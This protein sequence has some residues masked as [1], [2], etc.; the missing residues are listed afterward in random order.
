MFIQKDGSY[1]LIDAEEN[2]SLLKK[3]DP[4]TYNLKIHKSFFGVSY[5]FEKTTVYDRGSIIK[6]GV[7]KV[8][9]E[10]I[11]G[12]IS[13]EMEEAKE[14]MQSINKMGMLF[15]GK[16]GTGK[17]FLAGQIGRYIR[18][19]KQDCVTIIIN[20]WSQ[21]DNI[22]TLVDEIRK[23]A[24]DQTL[25]L[26]FDEFEKVSQ[27][28]FND[29]DFLSFLDG[30]NSKDKLLLIATANDKSRLPSTLL[31][32]PGRFEVVMEFKTNNEETWKGIVTNL[33]PDSLKEEALFP[34]VSLRVLEKIKKFKGDCTIDHIRIM[35]RDE[36]VFMLKKRKGA[37]PE[38]PQPI[39]NI[40]HKFNGGKDKVGYKQISSN[41]I[42]VDMKDE[43]FDRAFEELLEQEMTN[44]N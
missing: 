44:S 7:Y 43:L 2:S 5:S 12:F 1:R 25:V 23:F 4:A 39:E 41:E 26:I 6:E 10:K 32:R 29:S 17:T 36:I 40:S 15:Y 22:A 20:A 21:I 24:K 18:E 28:S 9:W 38:I 30:S 31:E 42:I 16:P 27:H 13:P 35:V 14:L 8:M 3:L 19:N 34:S 33:F 11:E 37:T